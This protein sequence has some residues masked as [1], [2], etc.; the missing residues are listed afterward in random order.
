MKK[1]FICSFLLLAGMAFA[2]N[3]ARISPVFPGC[4]DDVRIDF[5]KSENCINNQLSSQ[6]ADYL[7]DFAEKLTEEGIAEAEAVLKYTIDKN[8]KITDIQISKGSHPELGKRA[9]SALQEI[10]DQMQKNGKI[11]QPAELHGTPI[12]LK[13]KLPVKFQIQ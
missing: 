8:G 10:S 6:I 3:E 1:I 11:I 12:D 2:Q 9:K 13:M 5:E 4:S 7:T